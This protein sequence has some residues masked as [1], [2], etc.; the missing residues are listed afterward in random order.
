MSRV[1]AAISDFDRFWR[2]TAAVVI[3]KS[4]MRESAISASCVVV[5]PHGRIASVHPTPR[6]FR[7]FAARPSRS[8][9]KSPA[10]RFRARCRECP[11]PHIPPGRRRPRCIEVLSAR[12][13]PPPGV[14]KLLKKVPRPPNTD[15]AAPISP[16]SRAY[17]AADCSYCASAKSCSLCSKMLSTV[18]VFCVVARLSAVL[19]MYNP[20]GAYVGTDPDL[21]FV[22][23]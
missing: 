11:W 22:L 9:P 20:A 13:E 15:E 10:W 14:L 2:G 5:W 23:N 3:G 8:L 12:H 4:G 17:L 18:M 7:R 6:A 16:P 19:R 1:G 21:K